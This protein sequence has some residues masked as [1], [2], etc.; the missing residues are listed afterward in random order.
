MKRMFGN[1]KQRNKKNIWNLFLI[2]LHDDL[3]TPFPLPFMVI[4]FI[5]LAVLF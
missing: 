2:L 4:I 5:L 3:K 1:V